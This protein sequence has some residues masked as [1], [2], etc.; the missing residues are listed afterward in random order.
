M[1]GVTTLA[2]GN[3]ASTVK[4]L[5]LQNRGNDCF[6]NAVVQCIFACPSITDMIS[7]Y[8]RTLTANDNSPEAH[9]LRKLNSIIGFVGTG[10]P[11]TV[12]TL[13][14]HVRQKGLNAHSFEFYQQDASEFYIALM[15][16]LPGAIQEKFAFQLST[17]MTCLTCNVVSVIN[18]F[19]VTVSDETD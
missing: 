15:D 16:Q 12:G 13:R 2:K 1:P 18:Y 3:V 19:Q 9:I 4:T 8:S 11:T 10:N 14:T 17:T 7:D 6:A 5:L